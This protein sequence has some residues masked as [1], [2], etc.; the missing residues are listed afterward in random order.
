MTQGA[1][2]RAATGTEQGQGYE[3]FLDDKGR[4]FAT[5]VEVLN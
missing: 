4:E 5:L 3:R 1:T 2:E